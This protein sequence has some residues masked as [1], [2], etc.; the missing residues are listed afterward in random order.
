MAILLR[1][2]SYFLRTGYF[3]AVHLVIELLSTW[4]LY[5]AITCSREKSMKSSI[6][7]KARPM[8]HFW[9]VY[10]ACMGVSRLTAT[11]EDAHSSDVLRV[12]EN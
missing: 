4:P 12:T 9:S 11:V 6:M 5:I 1:F 8:E 10:R 2:D 3:V 7:V